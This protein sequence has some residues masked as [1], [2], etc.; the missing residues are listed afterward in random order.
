ME[1]SRLDSDLSSHDCE[2]YINLYCII[3]RLETTQM[4]QQLASFSLFL[5]RRQIIF[6]EIRTIRRREK[7]EVFEMNIRLRCS[8]TL[9]MLKL[10]FWVQS[11]HLGKKTRQKVLEVMK[12]IIK[13]L[14]RSLNPGYRIMYHGISSQQIILCA[15]DFFIELYIYMLNILISL[16][17]FCLNVHRFYCHELKR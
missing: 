7:S 14:K 6:C 12:E 17:T 8:I 15:F 1:V 16:N 11:L 10:V 5:F 13:I 4:Q 9:M 2:S 3:W